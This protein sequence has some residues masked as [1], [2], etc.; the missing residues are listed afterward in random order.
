MVSQDGQIAANLER[1]LTLVEQAASAG[2]QLI[3]LPELMPTGYACNPEM[4]DGGEPYQGPTVRWLKKHA[5]RLGAYLGTSFLEA[6]GEDF[7]N[8]FVLM[9]PDGIEAGR[10]RKQTPAAFEA[11]ITRGAPDHHIIDTTLGRIGVSICYEN[12]L[13]YTPRLMV[14]QGVDVMLMPHSAPTPA[15]GPLFPQKEIVAYHTRLKGLTSFYA[16]LLGIPAVMANKCGPWNSTIPGLAFLSR[17]SSFPGLSSIANSD[18]TLRSQLSDEEGVIIGDVTL[19]PARKVTTPPK[20]YGRWVGPVEKPVYLFPFIEMVGGLW[21]AL[22]RER[23][24]RALAI[25]SHTP[26]PS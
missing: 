3:L 15:P 2:A 17:E 21:Y 6:D 8:T 5:G 24:R 7:F 18:G 1:A 20:R 4:W 12:Q 22:S 9:T 26:E 23:K 14:A 25:S 11:F 19:D 16:K 13:A 10:V